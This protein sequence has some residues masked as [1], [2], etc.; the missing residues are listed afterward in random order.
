MLQVIDVAYAKDQNLDIKLHLNTTRRS[1]RTISRP[2]I[3]RKIQAFNKTR[4]KAN[5]IRKLCNTPAITFPRQDPCFRQI[6]YL[7]MGLWI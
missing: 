4:R 6:K 1:I 7:H 5:T 3:A 2:R